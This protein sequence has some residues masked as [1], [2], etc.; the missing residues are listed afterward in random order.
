MEGVDGGVVVER[1]HHSLV[2]V[3][4]P[5]VVK[6]VRYLVSLNRRIF[7]TNYTDQRLVLIHNIGTAYLNFL[8]P[9]FIQL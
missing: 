4:D 6:R 8:F 7:M 3:V 5:L 9:F 2:V 1:V